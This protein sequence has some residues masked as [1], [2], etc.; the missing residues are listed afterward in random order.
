M[1][2]I[3]KNLTNSIWHAFTA[4]QLD[5]SNT[6]TKSKLKVLDNNFFFFGCGFFFTLFN[7]YLLF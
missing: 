1:S 3:A 4:L 2:E 7:L 6:V 5:Q